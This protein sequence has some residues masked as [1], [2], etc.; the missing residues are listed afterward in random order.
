MKPA[1]R[2]ELEHAGWAGEAFDGGGEV[3]VGGGGS[4]DEAA[5]FGEEW[6]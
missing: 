2:D 5:E 6:S 3:T 4:G 1:S